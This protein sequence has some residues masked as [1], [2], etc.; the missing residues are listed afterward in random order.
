MYLCFIVGNVVTHYYRWS[1]TCLLKV[2]HTVI[3]YDR[4]LIRLNSY[5]MLH[6]LTTW[7]SCGISILIFL[8]DRPWISPWIKSISNQLDITCH[9][10]GS[11]LS[12]HCDVIA[13]DQQNIKRV[14]ETWDDVWR[15][16]FLASFMDSLCH[17]RNKMM[18]VLLWQ[19]FMCSL[20]YYIDVYFP[21]CCAAREINTKITLS[22]AHKQF[23]MRVHT[24]YSISLDFTLK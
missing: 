8:H 2:Y 17:V 21:R 11:Q 23:A 12:G 4:T 18:Y 24:L 1:K 10:F 16:S 7:A 6:I 19:L 22:W 20:E 5:E 14:S 9:V 15:S 13:N 3:I